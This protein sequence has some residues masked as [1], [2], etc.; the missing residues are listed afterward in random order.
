MHRTEENENQS[1]GAADFF[2][3]FLFF[4]FFFGRE[5]RKAPVLVTLLTHRERRGTLAFSPL[6]LPPEPL[7]NKK[8]W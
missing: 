7:C 6:Y 5:S 4:F 3:L 8:K 2:F 1:F